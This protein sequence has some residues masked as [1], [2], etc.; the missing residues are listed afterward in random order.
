M[1]GLLFLVRQ[2]FRDPQLQCD[3][4]IGQHGVDLLA[5]RDRQ[6][7]ELRLQLLH[8][9]CVPPRSTARASLDPIVSS[10]VMM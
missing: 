5:H 3:L 1:L 7:L 2:K 6:L 4:R 9:H 10:K 8:R